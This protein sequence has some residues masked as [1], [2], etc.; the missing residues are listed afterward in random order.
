MF[1]CLLVNVFCKR[2]YGISNGSLKVETCCKRKLFSKYNFSI[3]SFQNKKGS[4]GVKGEVFNWILSKCSFLLLKIL[5]FLKIYTKCQKM[6]KA[7]SQALKLMVLFLT[8]DRHL[9]KKSWFEWTRHK[10]GEVSIKWAKHILVCKIAPNIAFLQ[11]C[12]Q[13]D[14]RFIFPLH[15]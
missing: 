6:L 4:S 13:H 11:N 5:I 12:S 3:I 10:N 15:F 14:I 8:K 2:I 7:K 9:P 1:E